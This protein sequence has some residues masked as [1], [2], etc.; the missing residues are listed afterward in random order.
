MSRK[1]VMCRTSLSLLHSLRRPPTAAAL[2]PG[3]RRI[4][5]GLALAFVAEPCRGDGDE[6]PI[7][8]RGDSSTAAQNSKA[9]DGQDLRCCLRK[10][11]PQP[12]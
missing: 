1:S 9:L 5:A 11:E 8:T 6:P 10:A 3:G 4:A 12:T 7:D 2:L